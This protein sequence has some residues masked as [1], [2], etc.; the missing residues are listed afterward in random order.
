MGYQQEIV[1]HRLGNT[2]EAMK[3]II[4]QLIG[5]QYSLRNTDKDKEAYIKEVEE[6]IDFLRWASQQ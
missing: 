5:L 3:R 4:E 6:I 2:Q 1:R